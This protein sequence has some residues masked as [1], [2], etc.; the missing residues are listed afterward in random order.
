LAVLEDKEP[1]GEEQGLNQATH[2]MGREEI[3]TM[4][5]LWKSIAVVFGLMVVGAFA[6]VNW[7]S[8]LSVAIGAILALANFAYMSRTV[9]RSF[10]SGM[11]DGAMAQM[12]L[13]Y[14]IRFVLTAVVLTVLI[15]QG[16]AEPVGLLVGLSAV[17]AALVLWGIFQARRELG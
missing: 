7:F 8:A 14:Y 6:L 12:L 13:R 1:K 17:V 2:A 9:K 3:Q 16:W 4:R 10:G 11:V 15:W 5:A